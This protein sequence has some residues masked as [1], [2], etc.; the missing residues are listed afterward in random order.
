M[1]PEPVSL[2]Q[3]EEQLR[4]VSHDSMPLQIVKE[5]AQKIPKNQRQNIFNTSGALVRAPID[6]HEAQK[7]NLLPPNEDIFTLLQGDI[8]STESAYFMGERLTGNMKFLIG[9]STCDLVQQRRDY[10]ILLRITP[11]TRQNRKARE[12]LGELLGFKSTSRMY[13]PPLDNS[14]DII[15]N[16]VEFDGLAQVKLSDLLLAN[17]IASLSLVGWRIFGSLYLSIM[18]RTGNSE[19]RL[20]TEMP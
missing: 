17:R 19:V 14:S 5:F 3:L 7:L 20:R 15:C 2:K 8:I 6:Y 1:T 16:I 10:S 11:L 13:L 18:V 9:S 12:I 4:G